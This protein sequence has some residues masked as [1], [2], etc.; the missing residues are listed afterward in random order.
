[1][2][3]FHP[4]RANCLTEATTMGQA[5]GRLKRL[6]HGLLNQQICRD[7]SPE[8]V[9][10]S[11]SVAM[12]KKLII[13]PCSLS[14]GSVLQTWH[15]VVVASSSK[16]TEHTCYCCQVEMPVASSNPNPNP[17]RTTASECSICQFVSTICTDNNI[18]GN[19]QLNKPAQI[20]CYQL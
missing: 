18:Y 19:I 3:T 7:T 11:N 15:I 9:A 2:H 16:Q 6:H 14:E 8:M 12:Q 13:Q 4:N 20:P 17:I 5:R 10:E 1:M